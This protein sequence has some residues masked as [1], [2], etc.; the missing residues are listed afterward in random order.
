MLEEAWSTWAG[1]A[2]GSEGSPARVSASGQHGCACIRG[3]LSHCLSRTNLRHWGASR[4]VRSVLAH[5]RA[6]AGISM[7]RVCV[8]VRVRACVCAESLPGP[9]CRS[10]L[11]ALPCTVSGFLFLTGQLVCGRGLC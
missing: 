11:R 5:P 8:C 2:G 7:L 6:S 4:A 9:V 1:I 10:S 3:H